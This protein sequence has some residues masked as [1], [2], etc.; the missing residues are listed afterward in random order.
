MK[1]RHT[2]LPK[3]HSSRSPS[4]I[5]TLRR[6]LTKERTKRIALEQ[7][8]ESLKRELKAER[9]KYEAEIQRLNKELAERDELLEQVRAQVTWFR[10]NF[11]AGNRSERDGVR[12][13]RLK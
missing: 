11:L 8:V 13:T 1:V 2:S 4:D 5:Q 6:E 12:A 9:K 10:E 3:R 7:E